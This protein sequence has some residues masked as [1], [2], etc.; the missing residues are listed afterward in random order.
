MLFYDVLEIL[1][2]LRG[3][4]IP[5][6]PIRLCKNNAWEYIPRIYLAS[7]YGEFAALPGYF[8]PIK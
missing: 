4:S 2:A 8:L 5:T 3:C 1:L 7:I 6:K